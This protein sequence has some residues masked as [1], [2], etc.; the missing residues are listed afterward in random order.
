ML[1][2]ARKESLLQP[3]RLRNEVACLQ[4]LAAK[5]PSILAP[6]VYAWDDGASPGS[7][8]AF[9][10]EDFIEGQRLS[11]VWPQLSES[12]K[13]T[14]VREI[15]NMLADLGETRFYMIGG[16]TLGATAGPTIEAAKVFN[17]RVGDNK[18]A[19]KGFKTLP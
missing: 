13:T 8:P 14:I 6:K 2:I 19:L 17:G 7:G 3:Y 11:I 4:F 12:Q 15:A 16:L 1:R 5:V 9:I 10:V 18:A